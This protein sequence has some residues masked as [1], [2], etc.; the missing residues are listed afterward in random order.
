MFEV[1]CPECG[2]RVGVGTF[3]DPG[4]CPS[5]D[6]PLMLTAEFR[7][8]P[9]EDLVAEAKRRKKLEAVVPR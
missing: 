4:S 2:Y 5:C 1:V 8:L 9:R 7:A 3:S 6:L